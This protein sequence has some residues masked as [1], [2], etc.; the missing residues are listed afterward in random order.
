MK[1]N[2]NHGI[3]ALNGEESDSTIHPDGQDMNDSN[4]SDSISFTLAALQS[5]R[6]DLAPVYLAELVSCFCGPAAHRL[7]E[8]IR[9]LIETRQLIITPDDNGPRVQLTAAIHE[10]A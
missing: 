2:F 5:C 6:A 8:G 10:A 1:R 9:I 4:R 3:D 7:R